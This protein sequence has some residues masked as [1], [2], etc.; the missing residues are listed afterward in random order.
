MI[1]LSFEE[2][3]TDYGSELTDRIEEALSIVG[4]KDRAHDK[5]EEYSGGMKRRIN[6]A[7]ALLHY[8]IFS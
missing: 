7:A 1:I 4:M 3:F 2:A 6:I 5:V 8:L